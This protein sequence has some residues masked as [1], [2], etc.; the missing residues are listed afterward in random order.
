MHKLNIGSVR[1]AASLAAML[2][3]SGIPGAALAQ[4][5][6]ITLGAAGPLSGTY[7]A[8]A[9]VFDGMKAAFNMVN[10]QGGIDGYKI[11]FIV[12]DDQF[13]PANT[14]GVTRDLVETVNVA[15]ICGTTGSRN[16]AAVKDY[17]AARGVPVI[18]TSGSDTLLNDNTFEVISTY[19]QLGTAIAGFAVN[20]LKLKKI[21]NLYSDDATGKPAAEAVDAYLKSKGMTVAAS[22]IFDQAATDFTSQLA[23]IKASGAEMV[24]ANA[25]APTLARLINAG[26]QIGYEPLWGSTFAGA[27][28]SLVDLTN[29]SAKGKVYFSTPFQLSSSD[30]A[31][32]YRDAMAKYFPKTNINDPLVIQGWTVALGCTEAVKAAVGASKGG[33]ITRDLLLKSMVGLKIDNDYIQGLEWTATDH[34]GAKKAQILVL[35]DSGAFERAADFVQF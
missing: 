31:K 16:N 15:M 27:N 14:P 24:I 4:G 17:L 11:E 5:K 19:T 28:T 9:P 26:K 1:L 10:D 13:N 12:R 3:A 21:A 23:A 22:Q 29:G 30:S 34:S 6:T 35:S 32:S 2:L 25:S 7:A 18:P 20:N 8:L 33:D